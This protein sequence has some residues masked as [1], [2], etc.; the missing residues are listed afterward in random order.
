DNFDC[1]NTNFTVTW[2]L[3]PNLILLSGQGTGSIEVKG[4][5][6]SSQAEIT[7]VIDS[8]CDQLTYTREVWVG[9]PE[10]PSYFL[11][12]WYDPYM[13]R[14]I[15][16]VPPVPGATAYNW[17]VENLTFNNKSNFEIFHYEACPSNMYDIRFS[18]SAVNE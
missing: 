4:N 8:G 17:T 11:L 2:T 9:K 7:V 18:V 15:L 6:T 13:E 14:I 16:S 1:L 12:A 10:Q 5:S 3:T